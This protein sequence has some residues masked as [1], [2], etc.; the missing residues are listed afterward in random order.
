MI[1]ISPISSKLLKK[2]IQNEINK[3]NLP[4][5]IKLNSINF[6]SGYVK[7]LKPWSK[8]IPK[9]IEPTKTFFFSFWAETR[10]LGRMVKKKEKIVTRDFA[11]IP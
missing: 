5:L 7:K 11:P 3:F 2:V 10:F 4:I 9:G 8:L 6:I 1:Q